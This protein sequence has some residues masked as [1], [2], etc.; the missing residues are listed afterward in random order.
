MKELLLNNGWIKTGGCNCSGVLREEYQHSSFAGY[1]AKI[2][3]K[4]GTY[5]VTKAGKKLSEGGIEQLQ[6]YLNGLVA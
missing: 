2:Y 6:N 4:K 5:K 1:I 3:P